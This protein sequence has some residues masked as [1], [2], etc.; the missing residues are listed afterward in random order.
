MGLFDRA[1]ALIQGTAHSQPSRPVHYRVSCPEGHVLRGLRTEGFQAVRCPGCGVG[2]FILPRSPLP[3]PVPPRQRPVNPS[4]ASAAD[5]WADDGPIPLS[6]PVVA[7]PELAEADAEP[8]EI[9]WVDAPVPEID[10]PAPPPRAGARPKAPSRPAPI[11]SKPYRPEP[12][13][14]AAPIRP[15]HVLRP[16]RELS[17]GDWVRRNRHKLVFLGV[18]GLLGLT[19]AMTVRRSWLE[20]APEAVVRAQT[21]GIEALDQGEFD[22]ANQLL[23]KGAR[24]VSALRGEHQD[25]SSVR[26]AAEEAAILVNLSRS[27]LED[28]IEE[29]ARYDPPAS[30]PGRFRDLYRGMSVVIDAEVT[31]LGKPP[32]RGPTLALRLCTGNGPQAVRR[33]RIDTTG[34]A[35]LES[36]QPRVG[37]RV[38]FGA[39]LASLTLGGDGVWVYTLIPDS[40]VRITHWKALQALGWPDPEQ[41]AAAPGAAEAA[42]R[43]ADRSLRNSTDQEI[44]SLLGKPDHLARWATQGYATEQWL[45]QGQQG[46]GVQVI[47][48]RRQVGERRLI[49]SSNYSVP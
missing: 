47:N 23:S 16:R 36:V 22:R 34:L 7:E 43:R 20:S 44:R 38:V 25:A 33:G 48:Y 27:S 10:E 11:D 40:G 12:I 15:G 39:R 46:R 17:A 13:R 26:Q 21:E 18:F 41:E 31:D 3:E 30:W 9:E 5:A 8:A 45:Y 32:D 2:V 35:I 19:V 28:L 37:D 6:E 42:D 49:V 24:A 4:V 1:R 29:A 14:E